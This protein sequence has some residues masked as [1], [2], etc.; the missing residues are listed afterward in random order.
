MIEQFCMTKGKS[1][2]LGVDLFPLFLQRVQD[3]VSIQKETSL[4]IFL[5]QFHQHVLHLGREERKRMRRKT[6]N[7]KYTS[8]PWNCTASQL[9]IIGVITPTAL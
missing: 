2:S 7:V 4:F 3:F 6:K 8:T 5:I 9:W 1:D